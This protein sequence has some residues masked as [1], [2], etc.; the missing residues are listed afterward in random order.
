MWLGP[1]PGGQALEDGCCGHGAFAKRVREKQG[2]GKQMWFL[3]PAGRRRGPL[4][5]QRR[6]PLEFGRQEQAPSWEPTL[7]VGTGCLQCGDSGPRLLPAWALPPSGLLLTTDGMESTGV[8]GDLEMAP[9]AAVRQGVWAGCA[10][11]SSRQPGRG[12]A[13]PHPRRATRTRAKPSAHKA[14]RGKALMKQGCTPLNTPVHASTE[15]SSRKTYARRRTVAHLDQ[16][17][18]GT[19][20]SLKLELP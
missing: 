16:G 6:E 8:G 15:T 11:R 12:G 7:L 2:R 3:G 1:G 13:W 4:P 9:P 10:A 20:G 19:P 5:W 18:K 14:T 17:D